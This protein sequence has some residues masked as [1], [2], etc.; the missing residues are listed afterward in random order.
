MGKTSDDL[1]TLVGKFIGYFIIGAVLSLLFAWA[2]ETI[3]NYLFTA[4]FLTLV[5]GGPKILFWQA[6]WLNVLIG[7]GTNAITK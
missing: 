1:A 4:A 6:F 2:S 7:F 5:F 3:V